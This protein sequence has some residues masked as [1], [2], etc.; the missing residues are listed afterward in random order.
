MELCN[1]GIPQFKIA[2]LFI[3]MEILKEAQKIAKELLEQDYNLE[4]E[5]N[6]KLNTLIQDKF[7]SRIEI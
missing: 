2:N 3:D 7:K 4:L 6:L 1:I 5:K